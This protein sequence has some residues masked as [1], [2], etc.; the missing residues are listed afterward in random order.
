MEKTVMFKNEF[1]IP[2]IISAGFSQSVVHK[3]LYTINVDGF[4]YDFC[5]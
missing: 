5:T 1:Q 3:Y 2:D 4:H